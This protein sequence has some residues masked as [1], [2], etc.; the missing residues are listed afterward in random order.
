MVSVS[1]FLSPMRNCLNCTLIVALW[2]DSK[3]LK[4][5]QEEATKVKK[6]AHK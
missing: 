5:L 3:A 2:G 4:K 1:K 6:I